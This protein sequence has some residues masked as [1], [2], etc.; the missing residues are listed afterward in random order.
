MKQSRMISHNYTRKLSMTQEVY[1]VIKYLFFF[2]W[3]RVKHVFK[4]W[5]C[6]VSNKSRRQWIR[7]TD[8]HQEPQAMVTTKSLGVYHRNLL[9]VNTTWRDF[10]NL[11]HLHQ[12]INQSGWI[13]YSKKFACNLRTL[14][15]Y[16]EYTVRSSEELRNV[17]QLTVFGLWNCL[18]SH[19][20]PRLLTGFKFIQGPV[21]PNH[22]RLH[23]DE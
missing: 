5:K 1:R 23:Q 3:V 22:V 4:E 9:L 11:I 7:N 6:F 10:I 21:I 8:L 18:Q 16:S 19:C 13:Q 15:T 14:K 17:I 12:R 20:L 2:W